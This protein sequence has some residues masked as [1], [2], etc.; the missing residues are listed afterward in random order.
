MFVNAMLLL[1]KKE[2]TERNL[3]KARLLLFNF[4]DL[5]PAIYGADNVLYNVHLLIHLFESVENW[6]APWASSA[7]LYEDIGG[8]LA[9]QLHGTSYV[10]E[11][12]TRN[13]LAGNSLRML[14]GFFMEDAHN[15]VRDL[16]EQFHTKSV[17]KD[18][19]PDAF[20]LTRNVSFARIVGDLKL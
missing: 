3:H 1:A 11:Q 6:G 4:I 10:M 13:F 16:F 14:A 15:N 19:I 18:G 5:F 17:F 12:I 9:N 20:Q 2:I 7:F 8:F